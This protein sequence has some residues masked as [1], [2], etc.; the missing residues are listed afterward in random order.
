MPQLIVFNKTDLTRLDVGIK[1]HPCAKI[2]NVRVS[3]KNGLGLDDL[4]QRINELLFNAAP[5]QQ[6]LQSPGLTYS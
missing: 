5:D 2:E 6:E 4:R 1:R 3:A